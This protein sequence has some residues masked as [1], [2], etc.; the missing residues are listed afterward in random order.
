MG[1]VFKKEVKASEQ[2]VKDAISNGDI[3][4]AMA[5]YMQWKPGKSIFDDKALFPQLTKAAVKHE[6]SIRN[7][8]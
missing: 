1:Y 7:L 6:K 5:S 3:A 2:T 4:G 8:S